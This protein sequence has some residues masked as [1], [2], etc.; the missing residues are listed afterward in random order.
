MNGMMDMNG[1]FMEPPAILTF[2]EVDGT[3]ILQVWP[4]PRGTGHVT[5]AILED[6]RAA[7]GHLTTVHV[8]HGTLVEGTGHHHV[9]HLLQVYLVG[10][11][12]RLHNELENHHF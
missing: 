1:S 6:P 4:P 2:Y 7:G 9:V 3:F 5:A 10:S 11:A 8:V 12:K